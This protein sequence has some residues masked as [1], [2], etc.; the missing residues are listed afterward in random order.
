MKPE[1]PTHTPLYTIYTIGYQG[2]TLELYLN[3]LLGARVTLLCDVRW[4]P[5]SRKHGFSKT[6]LSQECNNVGI[7]YEHLRE[8]GIPTEKRNN[9][10]TQEDHDALLAEYEREML[11]AQNQA[12]RRI[13]KWMETGECVA[14]TCYEKNPEQCHRHCVADALSALLGEEYKVLHL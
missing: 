11:P 10:K 8:L 1:P 7:K 2:L 3:K 6:T 14:L 5:I 12:I 9:L 13:Q 4:N